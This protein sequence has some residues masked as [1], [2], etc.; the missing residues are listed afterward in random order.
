MKQAGHSSFPRVKK[1]PARRSVG[2]SMQK[3]RL[4]PGKGGA[5]NETGAASW[6]REF[7]AIL[8]GR[9]GHRP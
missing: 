4:E 3:P 5:G 1:T 8:A 6:R 2:F 9:F 7:E